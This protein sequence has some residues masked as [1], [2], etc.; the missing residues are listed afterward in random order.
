MYIVNKHGILHSWPDNQPITDG[1][2]LATEHE[3]ATFVAT[4]EQ[5]T[6]RMPAPKP[7]TDPAKGKK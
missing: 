4:G 3:I 2:R 5:N 6:Q 7:E 1:C